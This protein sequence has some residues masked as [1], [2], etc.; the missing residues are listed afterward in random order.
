MGV[1]GGGYLQFLQS[2]KSA[3][4]SISQIPDFVVAQNSAKG[5][6]MQLQK[7]MA[8]IQVEQSMAVLRDCTTVYHEDRY[9]TPSNTNKKQ[10]IK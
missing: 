6:E 9:N 5:K 10:T 1:G 7:S 3:E 2:I 8:G 4:G